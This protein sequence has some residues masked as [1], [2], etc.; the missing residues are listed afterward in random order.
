MKVYNGYLLN[1]L[2][3]TIYKIDKVNDEIEI[4][5]EQLVCE[6]NKIW[7]KK[8]YLLW[9]LLHP[10]SMVNILFKNIRRIGEWVIMTKRRL[11]NKKA[12]DEM[13]LLQKLAKSYGENE[14]IVSIQIDYDGDESFV[15]DHSFDGKW[16]AR[17][18]GENYTVIS[19][20]LI[21]YLSRQ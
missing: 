6:E 12:Y 21:E 11:I 3:N 5:K 8:D 18:V 15:I 17:I 16:K 13:L 14:Y 10:I 1:K 4:L 20:L 9:I 7:H 19:K 2:E